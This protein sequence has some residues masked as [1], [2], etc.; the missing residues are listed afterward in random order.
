MWPAESKAVETAIV[1]P[2]LALPMRTRASHSLFQPFC[3]SVFLVF[4]VPHT[5]LKTL[6]TLKGRRGSL[7]LF[8]SIII[9]IIIIAIGSH[10]GQAGSNSL[11]D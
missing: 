3:C 9:T 11:H 10:I 2:I 7:F 6:P 5:V 4:A 1:E 8:L